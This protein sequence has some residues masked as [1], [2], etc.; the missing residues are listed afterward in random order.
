MALEIVPI[1]PS[2]REFVDGLLVEHFGSTTIVSL[3]R[4]HDA[5]DLPGLVAILDGEN[6][7]F[8]I[9]AVRHD[10][11]EIVALVSARPRRGVARALVH[12][13]IGRAPALGVARIV[14]V[15]T[16]D[17]LSAQAFYEVLGFSLLSVHE[18]AVTRA[19]L[20]K[21]EIPLVGEGD[22]SIDDELEYELCP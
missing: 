1:D 17:N 16:N 12:D 18:G 3:G 13:V 10:V 6:A 19:R 22:R 8:L 2:R 20:L 14:L 4:V 5:R 9:F 21:P 7:G 11:L 15:T